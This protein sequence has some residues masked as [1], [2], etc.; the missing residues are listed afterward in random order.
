MTVRR[1]NWRFLPNVSV[2]ANS[3]KCQIVSW[4]RCASSKQALQTQLDLTTR[5]LESLTDIER[6]LSTRKP[7]GNYNADTPH[8]NDKPATSEDGA[9]PSPSQDEVTP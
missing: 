2:I 4:M 7:A 6:Q 9:A 5:K 1:C 8:T 3:S